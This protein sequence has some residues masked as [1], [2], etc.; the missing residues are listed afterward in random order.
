MRIATVTRDRG[1]HRDQQVVEPHAEPGDPGELLVLGD[2]EQ[3]RRQAERDHDHDHG[4][5]DGHPARRRRRSW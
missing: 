2:R 4:Q 5:H 3:L 1:E